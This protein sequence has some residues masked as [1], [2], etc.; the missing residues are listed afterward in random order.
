MAIGQYS[1]CTALRVISSTRIITLGVSL[2]KVREVSGSCL[3]S[4]SLLADLM[5]KRRSAQCF[6]E[7]RKGMMSSS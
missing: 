1:W 6:Y 3:M 2:V 4:R 5:E 7:E